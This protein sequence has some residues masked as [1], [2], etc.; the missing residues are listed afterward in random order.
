MPGKLVANDF[1]KVGFVVIEISITLSSS[2]VKLG[3]DAVVQD[4]MG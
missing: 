2:G 3:L 1:V 4:F